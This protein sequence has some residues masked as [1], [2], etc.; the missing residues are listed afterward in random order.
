VT[1]SGYR[2]SAASGGGVGILGQG[3]SGGAT[4]TP[5]YIQDN[6][7]V[8][9]GKGGSGGTDGEDITGGAFYSG[10]G[11]PGVFGGGSG[12]MSITSEILPGGSGA[13]RIIWG[14][15]RAFPSTL[16]GNL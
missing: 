1:N 2:I 5:I 14:A 11:N 6:N 15:G 9:G 7:T 8:Y 13:V 12:G 4:T 16:T 10:G 3:A